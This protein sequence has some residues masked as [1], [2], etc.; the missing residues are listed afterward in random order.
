MNFRFSRQS[1]SHDD[2][3]TV[4]DEPSVALSSKRDQFFLGYSY[5]HRDLFR[6]LMFTFIIETALWK[7]LN[8]P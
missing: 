2:W 4:E 7:F 8:L 3:A 5:I 1:E 6:F